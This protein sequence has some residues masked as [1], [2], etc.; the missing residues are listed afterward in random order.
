LQ[1][2][3]MLVN[4]ARDE[5]FNADGIYVSFAPTLGDP[6]AWSVPRKVVNRGGWYAQV[7]GLEADGTDRSAG[8]RARFFQTGKSEFLIEFSR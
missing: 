4:R 7:V 2:Y 1:Q 6:G 8:Q 5:T 3:V